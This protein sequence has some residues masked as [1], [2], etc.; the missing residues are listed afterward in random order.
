MPTD[1]S[2][3]GTFTFKNN[4][5]F[6][7]YVYYSSTTKFYIYQSNNATTWVLNTSFTFSSNTLSSEIFSLPVVINNSKIIL[8]LYSYSSSYTKVQ[9]DLTVNSVLCPFLVF[10]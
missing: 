9:S 8:T 1:I 6:I 2:I 7:A 5:Y 4:I 3:Y 10:Q